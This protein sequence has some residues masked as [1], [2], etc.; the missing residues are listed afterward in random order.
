[1]STTTQQSDD[2]KLSIKDLSRIMRKQ[3]IAML[4]TLHKGK[5]AV[6]PMSNNRDVD[7]DGDTYFF[8]TSDTTTVEDI[9]AD[10]NVTVS[11]QDNDEDT[12]IALTGEA[13]LHTDRETQE[14]HWQD[15]LEQWFEGGLDTEGLTLIKV[16][17]TRV[18]HWCGR[19]E[20]E[21]VLD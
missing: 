15:K 2:D 18:H 1:M 9:K 14:K 7:F 21:M 20:N 4:S 12:Y 16:N 13:S 5:V 10:P 17:A 3:D 8:T 19:S 11:Y 6:R